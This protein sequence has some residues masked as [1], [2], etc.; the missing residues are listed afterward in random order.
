MVRLI[1]VTLGSGAT[2]ITTLQINASVLAIQNNAAHV[3]RAGDNT[4]SAT[5]GIALAAGSTTTQPPFI[6]ARSDN[7]I[8]LKEYYLFGTQNDV[9]DVLYEV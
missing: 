1:Q 2:Q 8:L 6:I 3:C 5:K 4:V 9:I 7:R